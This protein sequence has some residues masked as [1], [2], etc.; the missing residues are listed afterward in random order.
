MNAL[1]QATLFLRE[2]PREAARWGR[3][4]GASLSL[5]GLG[6]LF[7]LW[8]L[9]QK[10]FQ[11]PEAVKILEINVMGR[12]DLAVKGPGEDLSLGPFP[13]EMPAADL[14]KKKGPVVHGNTSKLS[15]A[16]A[17]KA[18]AAPAAA[19]A[20]PRLVATGPLFGPRGSG[21]AGS[22]VGREKIYLAASASPFAGAKKTR[23]DSSNG[24]GLAGI[25]GGDIDLNAKRGGG[26]AT[27]GSDFLGGGSGSVNGGSRLQRRGEPILAGYPSLSE[28]RIIR[29]AESVSLPE[30]SDGFFSIQGPLGR[31][32]I[33]NMRL[34]RYPRWAEEEGVEAQISIHLVVAANGRVKPSLTIEQTS[35]FPDLDRVALESV[36]GIRF[37]ALPPPESYREEEGVATFNF[38]LRR[39]RADLGGPS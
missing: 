8:T 28:D 11:R 5:H 16:L 29:R 33:L 12:E 9:Q 7:M 4:M 34:P 2:P 35:G 21:G 15:S 22:G 23:E 30:P 20:P 31:R 24:E 39:R 3:P 25:P 27:G 37:A 6:A 38:K 13:D 26:E 1:D 32:K 14:P 18:A 36:Q 19:P 17:R 10:I